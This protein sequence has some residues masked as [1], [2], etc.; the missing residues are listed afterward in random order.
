[1][2]NIIFANRFHIGYRF[3]GVTWHIAQYQLQRITP[4]YTF[5]FAE[6]ILPIISGAFQNNVRN[7]IRYIYLYVVTIT[8]VKLPL[9]SYYHNSEIIIKRKKK[10]RKNQSITALYLSLNTFSLHIFLGA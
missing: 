4:S 10:E 1:M 6:T 8:T 2:K 3:I 7:L 9:C 5:T